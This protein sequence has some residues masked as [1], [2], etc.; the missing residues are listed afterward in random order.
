L[1]PVTRIESPISIKFRLDDLKFPPVV[2]PGGILEMKLAGDVIL[3]S[4]KTYPAVYVTQRRE[5]EAQ[6]VTEAN[7]AFGSLLTDTKLAYDAANNTMTY[8]SMLVSQSNFPGAV[9]TA[10]GIQVD[11][12]SPVPKLRFEFILPKIEGA[13]A[14]YAFVGLNVKIVVELTPKAEQDDPTK[15]L[16]RAPRLVPVPQEPARQPLP[17]PGVN[18]NYVV[19]GGLVLVATAIVVGTLVEDFFTAGAGIADDPVSFALAAGSVARGLQLMRGAVVPAAAV[20]AIVNISVRLEAS[21]RPQGTIQP[22]R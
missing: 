1:P 9:A 17:A 7:H 13:I 3:T 16:D 22:E 14:N 12:N 6:A 4:K 11:S 2:Q 20:P 8:R 21:T 15:Q 5:I 19:G 10:V 18:W